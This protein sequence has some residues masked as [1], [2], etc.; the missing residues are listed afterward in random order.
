[1]KR[2]FQDQEQQKQGLIVHTP[3][4]PPSMWVQ[5]DLYLLF[6]GHTHTS[7][8]FLNKTERPNLHTGGQHQGYCP[9]QPVPCSQLVHRPQTP[10]CLL[11]LLGSDE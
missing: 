2:H 6:I 7:V 5:R 8:I 10:L 1:M 4:I 3:H 9:V 11:A